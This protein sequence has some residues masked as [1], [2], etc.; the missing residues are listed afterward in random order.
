[1]KK[2]L[3]LLLAV[4]MTAS[5][6]TV[7]A[8]A[9]GEYLHDEDKTESDMYVQGTDSWLAS[10]STSADAATKASESTST[11]SGSNYNIGNNYKAIVY[12]IPLP[13]IADGKVIDYSEFRM[14]SLYKAKY[15]AYAYAIPSTVNMDTVTVGEMRKYINYNALGSGEYFLANV[16]KSAEYQGDTSSNNGESRNRF[17]VSNYIASAI[18]SGQSYVYLAAVTTSTTVKAYRHNVSGA[19]AR[20]YYTV[21]DAPKFDIT[22]T[23]IAEGAEGINPIGNVTFTFSNAVKSATATVNGVEVQNNDIDISG[24]TVKIPYVFGINE[25]AEIVVSATDAY[26]VTV[27]HALN[28]T[29][30][31][32][33]F[34]YNDSDMENVD[35]TSG[36]GTWLINYNPAAEDT[37]VLAAEAK[38][39][40]ANFNVGNAKNAVVFKMKLPEVPEGKKINMAEFRITAWYDSIRFI[41]YLYAM[42]GEK[43]NMNTMTIADAQK[44]INGN[45]LGSGD[46]FIARCTSNSSYYDDIT[47]LR[48]KYSVT[49]YINECIENG[50]E[51]VWIAATYGYTIKVYPHHAGSYYGAKLFYTF[52]DVPVV[53][54][55]KIVSADSEASYADASDIA[56]AIGQDIKAIC[57]LMNKTDANISLNIGVAQYSDGELVALNFG[58]YT[59]LAGTDGATV[60]FGSAKVLD[61]VDKIKVFMWDE[62]NDPA[63]VSKIIEVK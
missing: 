36:E 32:K 34:Y 2:L 55:A 3:A 5:L 30:A 45:K 21:K 16:M 13:S 7:P 31:S 22:E 29:T 39:A 23:S 24:I 17:D 35:Y 60:D 9:A 47:T 1:M 56:P 6:F 25:N 18:A 28:F 10:Y 11:L 43:W 26:G 20:I 54:G 38:T 58:D 42:P 27:S 52:E 62:D 4:L 49:D 57:Y 48:C 53:K 61:G 12:K 15:I 44:I 50:Q 8:F 51:Y 37:T 19:Q 46:N 14:S 40:T 33:Y 41:D 63:V 59:L